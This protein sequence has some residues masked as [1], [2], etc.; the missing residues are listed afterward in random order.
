M[1]D[2]TTSQVVVSRDVIFDEEQSWN[3]E[4]SHD[5]ETNDV[6]VINEELERFKKLRTTLKK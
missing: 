6:L 3:R 4:M 5:E 2:P 1:Y